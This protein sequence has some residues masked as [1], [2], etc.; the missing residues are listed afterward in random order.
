[1]TLDLYGPRALFARLTRAVPLIA[2][3]LM[4]LHALA[5]A[6]T[7]DDAFI[8]FRYALNLA[9]SLG[10]VYNA[11]QPV[12]GYTSPF[13]ILLLGALARLGLPIEPTALALSIGAAVLAVVLTPRLSRRL[14]YNLYGLDAL[15]LAANT[16][17]A[18]WA[19]A[20]MEMTVFA[21]V[22]VLVALALFSTHPALAGLLFALL[23]LVRPEGLLFGALALL[24]YLWA[25]YRREPGA[26]RS[27][28]TFAALFLAPVLIHLAWRL[29]FYGYPLPNTFYDKVGFS[30]AQLLRGL[31]YL[32]AAGWAYLIPLT[33]P[34]LLGL[35]TILGRRRLYLLGGL[36][37][38]LAYIVYV[39]G[40]WMVSFRLLTLVLPFIVILAA[41]GWL[42]LGARLAHFLPTQLT[43]AAAFGAA[44]VLLLALG[45]LP[46]AVDPRQDYRD[47]GEQ[48]AYWLNDHCP[49]GTRLAVYAAGAVGYYAPT[50]QIVDMFGLVKSDIAHLQVANI[51][52]GEWAGHEKFSAPLTLLERPN[53]FLFES[54]LAA[55]PITTPGEWTVTSLGH[56]TRQF[57]DDITFWNDHSTQS[58][59]MPGGK[60]LNFVVLNP[61][62]CR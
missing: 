35:A 50:M 8:S 7:P 2:A 4:F 43:R 52:E 60:H 22:L 38:Y 3:A 9:H 62:P 15:L 36:G 33:L 48:I 42:Q 54:T 56:L 30:V 53:V 58:A 55:A 41:A 13:W 18:V 17:F 23:S 37:A 24:Y 40:D 49:A 19:G 12:E 14:G 20:S 6:Y 39:G 51:G 57:T 29:S 21:L 27:L 59:P 46:G 25:I 10:P 16:S 34:L 5:R 28:L 31:R 26:L 44:V 61:Y 47:D 32:G 11:G 1:M 45:F